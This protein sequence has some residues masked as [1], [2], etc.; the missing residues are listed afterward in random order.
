[1]TMG[2]E[3]DETISYADARNSERRMEDAPDRYR[4][5]LDR[6]LVQ[7]PGERWVYNGGSSALIAKL[8][9][10][11]TGRPLLDFAHEHLFGP[12]GISELDWVVDGS[13]EPVAASGLR[14][15]P[16]DLAGSASSS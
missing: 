2:T 7:A 6:P 4:F 16:R 15:R 3:W 5:V 11:G 14:L 12:L 10:R 9:S 13:G 8:V 1:M